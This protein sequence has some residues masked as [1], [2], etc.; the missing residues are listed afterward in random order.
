M[1][2]TSQEDLVC[3]LQ[4]GRTCVGGARIRGSLEGC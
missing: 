3:G 2:P 1:K 4:L